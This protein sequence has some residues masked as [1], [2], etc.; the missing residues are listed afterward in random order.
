M[1]EV[2]Q[3]PKPS[4]SELL[5][6]GP[7]LTRVTEL[8]FSIPTDIQCLT[9]PKA[10]EGKDVIA[11]AK[12]GSGKTLAFVL[13]L[14]EK[15]D[16][17]KVQKSQTVALFISPTRELALQIHQVVKDLNPEL[18]P[19]LIIGG[20]D[21]KKQ[22]AALDKDA[23]V[24]V[25]TPGRL[26]D[27]LKRKVYNLKLCKYFVLDEADEMLSMGFIEDVRAILSRLPKVRQGLFVSATISPRVEML[28]KSFLTK[29]E[30][31]FVEEGEDDKPAIEHL[32]V[33]VSG[34]L[35]AKPHALCDIIETQRP[36]SAIIFCNTKSD[37][38][39]VEV[40][41]RRRGFDARRMN[42]DLS[43]S[44]RQTVLAK[45]KSEELQLL[46]ATDI[47]ARGIDIEQLDL[48]IINYSLHDQSDAYIHR[49]E[50][51]SVGRERS[52]N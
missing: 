39:L 40:L 19:V 30:Y 25:G 17:N 4:F 21:E 42:S 31:V 27:L 16:H 5:K 1:D 10:L 22:R 7:L 35:L 32:Y 14:L 23:R 33:E 8:G 45:I 18:E 28:A 11:K 50:Y 2:P 48:V 47:A 24:I 20:V 12:T 41:L 26:L 6:E 52:C 15:F 29:A 3:T 46:V 13:P 37:T 44:Q 34:D 49:A 36:R 51:R 9:L 38:E 43:Q